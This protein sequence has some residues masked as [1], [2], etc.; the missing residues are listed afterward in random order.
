MADDAR[1]TL[2]ADAIFRA[3]RE[4][5]QAQ[6]FAREMR[7]AQSG[8]GPTIKRGT[9]RAALTMHLTDA[10]LAALSEESRR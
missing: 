4:H 10:V 6:R 2:V 3:L 5:D 8:R 1:R 7:I 9:G